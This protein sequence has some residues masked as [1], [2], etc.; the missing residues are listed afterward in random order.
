MSGGWAQSW[1]LP[2]SCSAPVRP[3]Q[4]LSRAHP[5]FD[6]RS[7]VGDHRYGQ[8]PGP[9]LLCA[10][11]H[12]LVTPRAATVTV[13]LAAVTTFL[14]YRLFGYGLRHT[15]VHVATTL[16]LGEPAV[17]AVLGGTVLGERLSMVSW[18]G[19]AVLALCLAFLP[20]P[21]APTHRWG[22]GIGPH[23]EPSKEEAAGRPP[24]RLRGACAPIATH[25]KR[26]N[27]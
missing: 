10:G 12:W 18:Y 8:L 14:A 27:R 16:T 5:H 7:V 4:S 13:H 6:R 21:S 3:Y 11:T 26:A 17:A 2:G 20:L 19:L 15:A 22:T 9:V 24:C 1:L 25:T 23:D